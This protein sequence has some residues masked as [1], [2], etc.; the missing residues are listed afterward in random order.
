M[1]AG[2]LTHTLGTAFA[3]FAYEEAEVREILT[4]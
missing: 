4:A 2:H 3:P 1:P